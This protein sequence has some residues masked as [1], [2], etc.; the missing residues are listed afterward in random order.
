MLLA[1]GLLLW[2]LDAVPPGFQH[3]QTFQAADAIRVLG[4]WHPLYFPDNFGRD[5]FFIYWAAVVFGLTG[6]HYVW[7]LRFASV[8]CGILGVAVTMSVA[9]RYLQPLGAM[10]AAALLA[11]S[12]GF[13]FA[14]R[15][16]LEPIALLLFATATFY[17]LTRALRIAL[18][19]RAYAA[20]GLLSGAAIYTYL[21]SRTLYAVP[22]LLLL[23]AGVSAWWARRAGQGGAGKSRNALIGPILTLVL[24]ALVG[25]PLMLYISAHAGADGRV[26][27]LSGGITAALK[28]NLQPILSTVWDTTV[29]ILWRG[30]DLLPYQYN[31]PGRPVLQPVFAICLVL[32]IA[33]TLL[34][35]RR[36]QEFL[37]LAGLALGLAPSI[38]T[39][40]DALYMRSVYTLPLLFILV[41]AGWGSCS[42]QSAGQPAGWQCHRRA[43]TSPP[44]R[45]RA[46]SPCSPGRPG[47]V[48]AT[49]S[50]RGRPPSPRSASTTPISTRQRPTSTRTQSPAR[51]ST[52]ARIGSSIL[53]ATLTASTA[54]SAPMPGGSCCPARRP[55][56]LKVRRSTCCRR[57]SDSPGR[58]LHSLTSCATASAW[59]GRVG[60]TT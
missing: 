24:M 54:R 20:A 14:A 30:S 10:L 55:S 39:S 5:P 16:G 8:L 27:E 53:T 25:A 47:T 12:F 51:P 15:L 11:G 41:V 37:L 4:G 57:R 59:V 31:I 58:S 26:G 56:P 44:L 28:G 19:S 52:S 40:A 29:S 21:A 43:A 13:L 17:F 23:Y 22:V 34:T 1:W 60:A 2:R 46:W 6:G 48:E 35:V 49:I 7:S 36:S 18:A 3:D 50:R 9:R 33:L 32:G 45:S 38:L 42:S